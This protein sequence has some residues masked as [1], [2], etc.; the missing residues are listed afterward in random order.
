VLET[1]TDLRKLRDKNE[2]ELLNVATKT[3]TDSAAWMKTNLAT[4]T[5]E[6]ERIRRET[7][8]LKEKMD[9]RKNTI[10]H[11]LLSEIDADRKQNQME[12]QQLND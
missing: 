11:Q 9:M 5:N 12:I 6:D 4:V 7:Q 1:E 2:T 8:A 10:V 3:Q